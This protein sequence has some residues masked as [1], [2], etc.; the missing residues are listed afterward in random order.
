MRRHVRHL[1]AALLLLTATSP[2]LALAPDALHLHGVTLR[3]GEAPPPARFDRAAGDDLHLIHFDRALGERDRADL[4]D[5]GAEIMGYL[6]V[7]G[8]LLR[9]PAGREGEFEALPDVDLLLPFRPEWRLDPRLFAAI[10]RAAGPA[11]PLALCFAPGEPVLR[12]ADEA[13]ALGAEFVDHSMQGDRPLLWLRARPAMLEA[14]A[15][16]PGLLWLE[17]TGPIVERN[18]RVT[19]IV[20]SGWDCCHPVWEN[21]IHGEGQ[22]IGHID[23]DFDPTVC[24]FADPEG[25]PPGPDHRKLAFIGAD[26]GTGYPRHGTH[27]AGTLAGDAVP[28]DGAMG[29]TAR[30]LAWAA[31]LANSSYTNIY[32]YD[33][34][35]DFV[36]HSDAGARV[37]SNSYGI[38]VIEGTLGDPETRYILLSRSIDQFSHDREENLVVFAST[39]SLT[40]RTP[41]NAK[42]VLAVGASWTHGYLGDDYKGPHEHRYGG[43]GPTADGRRKPEIYAPGASIVSAYYLSACATTT[44]SGTS[45]ACPAIAAGA[46]LVRQY[47]TDGFFPGG[48]ADPENALAPSGALLKAL[49]LNSAL[50][51]DSTSDSHPPEASSGYPNDLEGWGRLLLDEAL[52][53]DGDS[54]E[55]WLT[56]LRNAEGLETGEEYLY[57]FE[58]ESASEPLAITMA[59]TDHPGELL[60]AAP[61]VNNLD[62][63]LEGPG[64]VFLGNV[65]DTVAEESMEGGA[66]DPLNTVERII[67]NSPMPGVWTLRVAATAVPMGPQGY[68]LAVN[69]DLLGEV[70]EIEPAPD[71]ARLAQNF[72]NPF[73]AG[74]GAV[75]TLQFDLPAGTGRASLKVFDVAGRLVRVLAEGD[76]LDESAGE[77]RW[78][79]RDEAGEKAASGIYF[80]QLETDRNGEKPVVRIMLLR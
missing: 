63:S 17:S 75:T 32:A 49:M 35:A 6:P 8:Y 36:L 43:L 42:S 13:L 24:F 22:V 55:L 69:G 23:S 60:A 56:E 37:H 25:D 3:A 14:L 45:M 1:F 27:T 20:Q 68:G 30:G 54:R 41:E 52:Y 58:V 16:L 62:L 44:S 33:P 80:A 79:G 57:Q 65:F 47:L 29:E 77:F 21:G 73:V 59:F 72:P 26:P 28:I 46:T 76:E 74:A 5:M 67:L 61:V 71:R 48:V 40:L 2:A 39:N 15:S 78:D 53:F 66:A 10:D 50:P 9:L 51:M 64:G 11:L 34:Y 70:E 38:D 19:W 12:R 18:D 4:L 7:N 31:R